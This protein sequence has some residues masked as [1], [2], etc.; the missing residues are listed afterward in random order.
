MVASTTMSPAER[1]TKQTADPSVTI[2][3]DGHRC[4]NWSLCVEKEGDEG[5]SAYLVLHIVRA[6]YGAC[7]L[8]TRNDTNCT[9]DTN[10]RM[11]Y[12]ACLP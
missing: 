7:R 9:N 4:K 11:K 6:W 12:R 3:E 1:R 8:V 2:C 10:L 5:V